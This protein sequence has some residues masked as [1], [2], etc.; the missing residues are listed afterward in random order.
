MGEYFNTVEASRLLDIKRETIKSWLDAGLVKPVFRGF[1]HRMPVKLDG[2]NLRELAVI[3]GLRKAGVSMQHVKKAAAY[4]KTKGHNP[5][6]KGQFLVQ[7]QT[8]KKAVFKIMGENE[9][10]DLSK[11]ALTDHESGQMRLFHT[12]PVEIELKKLEAKIG[13]G[14]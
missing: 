8:G 14:K 1:R 12:L 5:M 7:S 6:S 13:N 11:A 4:L 3:N 2:K 10:I 9:V